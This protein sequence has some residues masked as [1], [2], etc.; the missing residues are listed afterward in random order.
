MTSSRDSRSW[1]ARLAYPPVLLAGLL[2]AFA[3]GVLLALWLSPPGEP[4]ASPV[5]LEPHD[6]TALPPT[7]TGVPTPTPTSPDLGDVLDTLYLDIAPG[8]FARIE[9]KREEALRLWIL[10]ASDADFVPATVRLN[11]GEILPAEVRL[12]GDWADHLARD[13]WSFRVEMQ[14]DRYLYGMQVFSLQDPSM[15]TYLN[16]WLFLRNLRAEALLAVDYRFVRV[17]LNGEYKGIYALEEGFGKEL[18]ESQARREGPIIRYDEDL[19]WTARAAYAD[20]TLPPGIESFYVIDAF[21]SGRLQRSPALAAQRDAALG[22]LRGFWAGELEAPEVFDLEAMG[23][24]LALSDLW[25]APH[26]LIWHNLRY[27][28][29]PVTARLEPVGFDADP[30]SPELDFSLV[31][32]PAENFYHDPYLQ[33]AYAEALW[34]IS[35]PGYVEP[36]EER[37]GSE[38]EALRGELLAEFDEEVLAPPW[39][40]LR[41]RQGLIRQRLVPQQMVYAH[42]QELP[43]EVASSLLIEVGNLMD[44][45]VEIVG[46]EVGDTTLE[47]SA[48][49]RPADSQGALLSTDG[50]VLRALPE[51]ARSLPYVRLQVPLP[52]GVTPVEGELRL[53]TR[54]WGLEAAHAQ[55]VLF[56][57]PWAREESPRPVWPDLES[58]LAAHPYLEVGE[59]ADLLVV[60]RGAWEVEGDLILPQGY[61][62]SAGPGTALRFGTDNLL[63]ANGPLLFEGTAEEPVVLEPQGERWKGVVVLEA[64]EPSLWRHTTVR[65]TSGVD[66]EG[67]SLTGG[68]TFYRSALHLDQSRIL[69]TGAEDALNVI[70]APFT[71]ADSEFAFTASDAFDG[72]FADGLILRCTFHDVAADAIDVS[73][74]EVEVR[75]VRLVDLGDKGLSVGEGSRLTGA[76]ISVEGADFGIASKDRSQV[77]VEDVTL[78][79]VRIAGLAAYIKKPAYGPASIV[80]QRVDFGDLPAEQRLLVQTGSWIDLD[81]ERTWGTDVD[82][83]QLYEKWR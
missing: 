83:E 74:A 3:A 4:S 9:A 34:R 30:F 24:F 17:V 11:E 21:Q 57:Y 59:E 51:D 77:Q 28:Y 23:T 64:D 41:E 46:L 58:A 68:I 36:L 39:E 1:A 72:D 32:F 70:R 62:L 15:R 69:G 67:W 43:V 18:L 65:E 76:E 10:L 49:W 81:G 55:P 12:K 20:Q 40:L 19:L 78:T 54:V 82:V 50:L 71:F 27:Y 38:F 60:R 35:E 7:P 14:D 42:V 79:G 6:P 53:L 25:R 5:A 75:N 31:G 16:E 29:N 2:L 56:N 47:A 61:G 26:G 33:A 63:L 44:L 45:P 80:A 66:R 22:L 8:D 48:A 13:K 73:G 52:E 37:W